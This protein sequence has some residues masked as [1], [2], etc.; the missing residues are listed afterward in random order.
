MVYCDLVVS[1]RGVVAVVVC[2]HMYECVSS[3][4]FRREAEIE[5]DDKRSQFYP[6]QSWRRLGKAVQVDIRLTLY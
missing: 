2:P 5:I 3:D 1:C 6:Y 4:M